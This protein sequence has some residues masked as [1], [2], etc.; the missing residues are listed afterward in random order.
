MCR[1]KTHADATRPVSASQPNNGIGDGTVVLDGQLLSTN[2]DCWGYSRPVLVSS[3]DTGVVNITVQARGEAPPAGT[4]NAIAGGPN[5]VSLGADGAP[6][7]DIP[8]DDDNI[9]LLE[10]SANTALGVSRD[11]TRV[12]LVTFDGND[13]C[14]ITDS[15]CGT[16]TYQMA[17]FFMVFVSSGLGC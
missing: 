6:F 13:S 9:N 15:T 10:H 3:S 12:H 4:T 5:L 14:P 2:C 1:G 8:S 17:Y 7:I 16:N 11:G